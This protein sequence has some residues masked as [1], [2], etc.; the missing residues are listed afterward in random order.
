ME[1]VYKRLLELKTEYDKE[2]KRSSDA[3]MQ[4]RIIA[5]KAIKEDSVTSKLSLTSQPTDNIDVLLHEVE[6]LLSKKYILDLKKELS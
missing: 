3:L 4:I 2:L 1:D 6:K 5:N